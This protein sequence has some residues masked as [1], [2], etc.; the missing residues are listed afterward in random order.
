LVTEIEAEKA[1]LNAAEE[2]I[3]HQSPVLSVG[4]AVAAEQALRRAQ[5]PPD[6]ADRLSRAD[7][8]RRDRGDGSAAGE[9][10]PQDRRG[11]RS[12]G[13]TAV[14][15]ESIDLTNPFVNPVYQTLDLQIA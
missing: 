15:P 6:R 5:Q 14:D 4:R 12:I 7:Q 9:P 11:D 13:T 3:K 1:R 8:Q 2:E 10:P